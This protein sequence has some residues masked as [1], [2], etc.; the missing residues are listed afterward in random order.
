MSLLIGGAVAVVLGLIGFFEWWDKVSI[1]ILGGLPIVLVF[2]G[3]LAVYIGIDDLH[4]K[5]KEE[6]LHQDEKLERA[7][8]E[9]LAVKAKADEYR[10]ELEKLK[11]QA[12]KI[13]STTS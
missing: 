7:R 8:E 5:L 4:E 11:T 2:G 1:L 10:E 3:A 13:N 12:G 9:I 6:R